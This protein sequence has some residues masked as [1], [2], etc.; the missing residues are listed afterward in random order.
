MFIY[1]NWDYE[2]TKVGIEFV[3]NDNDYYCMDAT[4]VHDYYDSDEEIV[5]A[6]WKKYNYNDCLNEMIVYFDKKHYWFDGK[7]IKKDY[8]LKK[9]NPI[10]QM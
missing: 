10:T 3:D 5:A 1:D 4:V 2:V 6:L 7:T 8:H 9:I